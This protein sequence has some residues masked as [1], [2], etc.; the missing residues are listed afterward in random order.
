MN[1]F[2]SNIQTVD[3]SIENNVNVTQP[4][5]SSNIE[6][7]SNQ[8]KNSKTKQKKSVLIVEESESE[9]EQTKNSS[10]TI[11]QTV[12]SNNSLLTIKE[13]LTK[14]TQTTPNEE[15]NEKFTLKFLGEVR[16]YLC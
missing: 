1:S 15:S 10:S 3:D 14:S 11:N 7:Q 13:N 16:N 2:Q 6:S 8:K 5:C 9:S 12:S 4:S